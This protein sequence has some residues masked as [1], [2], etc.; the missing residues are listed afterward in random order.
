MGFYATNLGFGGASPS[1]VETVKA[2]EP[3]TSAALAVSNGLEVLTGLE[4]SSL[5]CI[6]VGV[7]L[8]TL[9]NS[10]PSSTAGGAAATATQ[11]QLLQEAASSPLLASFFSCA[12]VMTANLCFSFRGLYQKLF[13]AN[14]LQVVGKDKLPSSSPLEPK[15]V[16]D[17]LNLQ[18]RMQQFGVGLLIV[19][20]ILYHGLPTLLSNER[21]SLS[22]YVESGIMERYVFLALVNG[23]AFTGYK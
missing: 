6:V 15:L 19:P 11:Q 21:S 14:L 18:F 17:D 10:H 2:A 16:V 13:M 8:S 23:M 4:M 9:G 5:G 7:L 22:E 12:I 3:I 1:F 20:A